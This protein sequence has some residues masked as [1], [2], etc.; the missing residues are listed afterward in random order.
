MSPSRVQKRHKYP[1]RTRKNIQHLEER[2][3]ETVSAPR[4]PRNRRSNSTSLAN[5]FILFETSASVSDS[6]FETS[7]DEGDESDSESGEQVPYSAENVVYHSADD[8]SRKVSL[9]SRYDPENEDY[10]LD[11]FVVADDETEIDSDAESDETLTLVTPVRRNRKARPV[12]VE[13][14]TESDET[15]TPR[16]STRRVRTAR[17]VV[18][19]S[20]TESDESDVL[21]S[22]RGRL[23]RKKD[24]EQVTISKRRLSSIASTLSFISRSNSSASSRRLSIIIAPTEPEATIK[25]VI[26]CD[27]EEIS[28]AINDAIAL[29]SRRCNRKRP[30]TMFVIN[31]NIVEEEGVQNALADVMGRDL[32]L[33]MD[34]SDYSEFWVVG[35]K[36]SMR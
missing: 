24:T 27:A 28:D 19:E 26:S 9:D 3:I 5:T 31:K 15:P 22:K 18:V 29:Y 17:R 6:G 32:L 20:D 30:P 14:D 25:V 4:L 12:V 34:G 1:T 2:L 8:L 13:S 7:D 33:M 35:P 36:T 23:I 11:D 21:K 16:K 10:E